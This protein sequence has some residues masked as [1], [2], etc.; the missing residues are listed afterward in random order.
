M[1]D[2]IPRSDAEF[3]AWSNHL[4]SYVFANMANLGLTLAGITP[5][6]N[7]HI[8]WNTAYAAHLAS[9]A[10]AQGDASTKNSSRDDF[11]TA[12]RVFVRQLQASPAVDDSE[13]EAMNLTVA[14][15]RPPVTIPASKTRPVLIITQRS[16]LEQ[17]VEWVDETTP[18]S[19]ARPDWARGAV[20]YLKVGGAPPLGLQGCEFTAF[21]T[22]SPHTQRWTDPAVGGQKAY[23][24]GIWQALDGSLGPLSEVVEE[25]ILA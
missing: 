12:L 16:R 1:P 11:E 18:G 9:Q 21:D 13:R 8:L 5:I 17:Q 24:I 4:M 23:W 20:L 6:L 19:V 25:T 15:A 3:A 2:Y 7:L 22:G 10:Q 14:G